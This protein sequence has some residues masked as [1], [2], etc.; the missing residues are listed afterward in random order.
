M[1]RGPRSRE[2]APSARWIS[3]LI[4][5]FKLSTLL[6]LRDQLSRGA[7]HERIRSE[8]PYDPMGGT[9]IEERKKERGGG[10]GGIL[11]RI[12]RDGGGITRLD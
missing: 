4:S 11:K 2:I 10:G 12:K 7:H 8:K 9:G 5:P 3:V 6:R 1:N